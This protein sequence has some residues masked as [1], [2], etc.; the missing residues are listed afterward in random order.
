M[1]IASTIRKNLPGKPDYV[2]IFRY[3][4]G[5]PVFFDTEGEALEK[6]RSLC[7]DQ[8]HSMYSPVAIKIK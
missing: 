5:L 1:Y 7:E 4:N 8:A 6:A 3:S 2:Y